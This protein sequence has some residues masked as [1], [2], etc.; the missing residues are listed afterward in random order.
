M[1]QQRSSNDLYVTSAI[2][3]MAVQ[4]ADISAL[5]RDYL[6][7]HCRSVGRR[8]EPIIDPESR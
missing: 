8:L 4:E 7:L 1:G 2:A 3:P 5:R 6:P